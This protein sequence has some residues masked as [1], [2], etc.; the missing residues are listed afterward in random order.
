M[1]PTHW[2]VARKALSP[3]LARCVSEGG[4]FSFL[5]GQQP[6]Q[7]QPLR[8]ILLGRK[9]SSKVFDVELRDEDALVHGPSPGLAKHTRLAAQQQSS[10]GFAMA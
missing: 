9:L 8:C 7:R 1:R 4:Q 10:D 6:Q 3:V 5:V 2:R